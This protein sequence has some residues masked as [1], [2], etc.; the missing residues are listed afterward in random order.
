MRGS[1]PH[2]FS[3]FGKVVCG[4]APDEGYESASLGPSPLDNEVNIWRRWNR[5]IDPLKTSSSV[6]FAK[7]SMRPSRRARPIVT[8]AVRNGAQIFGVLAGA[9]G[10][11]ATERIRPSQE[12]RGIACRQ[13]IVFR[14]VFVLPPKEARMTRD[15][16]RY[17]PGG[18]GNLLLIQIARRSPVDR[19][20][21]RRGGM[22]RG[23]CPPRG[24][25]P[26]RLLS[27][28]SAR[29]VAIA[30]TP[31]WKFCTRTRIRNCRS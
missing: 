30:D 15:T 10:V 12:Y 7:K 27:Q 18:W 3:L 24:R 19:S 21:M 20:E 5:R 4:V 28:S 13:S 29:D 1:P 8:L 31:D 17:R 16:I 23:P 25:G 22:R 14:P 2:S 11:E 9:S 6:R 26:V